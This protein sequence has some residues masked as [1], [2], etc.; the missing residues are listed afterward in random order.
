MTLVS[1]ADGGVTAEPTRFAASELHPASRAT[2]GAAEIIELGGGRV[3]FVSVLD[4][5]QRERTVQRLR[6]ERKRP[7]AEDC[8]WP[9]AV[10]RDGQHPTRNGQLAGHTPDDRTLVY[11]GQ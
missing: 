5:S 7:F 4:P 1:I 8:L 3:L 2:E 6:Q 11:F 10:F 9:L